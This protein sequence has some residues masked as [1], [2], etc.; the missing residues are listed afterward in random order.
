LSEFASLRGDGR[1][2][3]LE[4]VIDISGVF[5]LVRL[6]VLTSSSRPPR[7]GE[8]HVIYK[9][10]KAMLNIVSV[11]KDRG[12]RRRRNQVL[13]P[14]AR[15]HS[16]GICP[17][18]GRQWLIVPKDSSYPKDDFV[19]QYGIKPENVY[20][21]YVKVITKGTAPRFFWNFPLL[22]TIKAP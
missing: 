16:G 15:N 1:F 20:P 12:F 4:Y 13:L 6:G 7:V 18:E 14:P 11:T 22:N 10:Y 5:V 3:N 21:C 17:V 19:T 8:E 9:E 2:G